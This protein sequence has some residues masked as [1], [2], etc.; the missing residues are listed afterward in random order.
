MKTLLFLLA[1]GCINKKGEDLLNSLHCNE[2]QSQ[3]LLEEDEDCDG[4]LT[5]DDCDDSDSTTINDM[6]CDG[7]L[8][9]DDCD[10]LDAFSTV[11]SED[12]DCDGVLTGDDCDDLDAGLLAQSGDADCDGV[13]TTDDCDDTD[14]DSTTVATDADCDT[15]LTVDDCDDSAP[16]STLV[17]ED[18]DCDTV[19]TADDCDDNDASSTTVATDADCDGVLTADDCDDGDSGSTTV[20]IDADCDG[21]LTADDCDDGDFALGAIS[22]DAN[23]DGFQVEVVTVGSESLTFNLI[24]NGDGTDL[25]DPLGRYTLTRDFYMMT[26]E[27]T[28]GIFQALMGYAASTYSTSYGIGDDYPAYYVNW[29]MAADAAN[30]LS[31][32]EGLNSCYTCTGSSTSVSCLE[33]TAYSTIYDCP[34][35]RLP[36]EAEWE[37]A[38]RSGTTSEFWTGEGADLGGDYSS[39]DCNGTETISDGVSNPLLSDYA[40]YCGNNSPYSSKEVAQLLPNG[41]GLY[42]MHGNLF[43]WV[44]D[45]YGCSYPSSSTDPVCASSGSYRVLR[46]GSW[47][48]DPSIARASYRYGST[49]SGRTNSYGFRLSR[50]ASQ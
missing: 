9:G 10:D 35:Y 13:L 8:T 40:W 48:G 38:A 42:D 33:N 32:Q 30:A 17:S 43:E 31:S 21:V 15:V 50:S 16:Q 25:S 27:V 18:A 39:N 22:E 11:A 5:A 26:T 36:T 23:C 29:Y 4:V 24:S 34:G 19:L 28:Q 2:D 47:N 7:V 20:A 6:D 45:W 1:T 3:N 14:A 41:F 37:L 49:P 44:N 12:M 46:G